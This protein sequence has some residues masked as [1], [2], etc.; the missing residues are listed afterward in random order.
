[1]SSL[2]PEIETHRQP[3]HEINPQFLTR[4]SPRSFTDQEVTDD[5]L[6]SLFE[7]ARWAPSGGNMQPWRFIIA[8]NPE[9]RASFHSFIVPGNREWC[10]KAP[11]LALVLSHKLTA[12]GNP[13]TSH[14]FDAGTAW[15]YLALEADNQGLITHAMGGFDKQKARETLQVPEEYDLHAVIAIGYRGAVDA[16][17]PKFHER[18]VP[19]ARVPLHQLLFEGAFGKTM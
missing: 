6:F 1:M 11:V 15:G 3:D 2:P 13:N 9:D 16:L 18:E 19:S 7:A 4:W 8:R 17:D 10:E 5:V 14:T 12:N